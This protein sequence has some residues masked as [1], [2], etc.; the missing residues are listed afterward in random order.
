MLISKNMMLLTYVPCLLMAMFTSC[1]GGDNLKPL[2]VD[3]PA[4]P[5]PVETSWSFDTSPVWADEFDKDGTPDKTKWAYDIG[6]GSNGWG[7]NELQYYTDR[8]ENA[9]VEKGVLKITARREA[10]GGKEYTS[11]RMV[12]KGKGDFLYGRFE[13]RAKLP[14]GRGT[15]PALWMLPSDLSYG[16]WPKSGEIDIMEHVGYDPKNVHVTVHTEAYNG[17]IG[18]QRGGQAVIETAMS[19]FHLYRLDWTPAAIKGYIDD[20]LV[21]EFLNEKKG[22]ASWPFDKKFHLLL[23]VAVGGNWGGQKG[24]DPDVFPATMEVDYVRVFKLI[25]K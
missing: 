16:P 24:V 14:Q 21:F 3:P 7:N 6:T 5:K 10:K 23:N 18:T 8:P 17:M 2:P 12:S 1:S 20:K 13:I 19:D 9:V 22:Y 15:W 11:S 4:P 25:E